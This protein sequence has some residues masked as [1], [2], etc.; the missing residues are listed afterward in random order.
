VKGRGQERPTEWESLGRPTT[1]MEQGEPQTM[2]GRTYGI[3]IISLTLAVILA[4]AIVLI[5]FSS[6]SRGRPPAA[7]LER[8][9]LKSGALVRSTE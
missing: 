2:V 8:R 4:A 3:D 7:T 9:T 6:R 1:H 5:G